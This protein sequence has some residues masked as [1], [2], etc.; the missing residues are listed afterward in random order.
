MPVRKG[1]SPTPRMVISASGVQHGGRDPEG[2]RRQVA[3]NVQVNR[4]KVVGGLAANLAA[5]GPHVGALGSEDAFGVVARGGGLAQHRRPVGAQGGQD[6][7]GLDLGA[8][9]GNV[10]FG[11]A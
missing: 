5:N 6:D 11:R 10:E 7:G 8:G 9:H 2:G 3:G 4:L 1:F